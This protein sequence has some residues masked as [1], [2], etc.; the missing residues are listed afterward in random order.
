[1]NNIFTLCDYHL[2]LSFNLLRKVIKIFPRAVNNIDLFSFQ[3]ALTTG[4]KP[5]VIS[6]TSNNE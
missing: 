4:A 2:N 5:T 3:S 6:P 1:M